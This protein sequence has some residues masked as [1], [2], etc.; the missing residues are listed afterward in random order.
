MSKWF[1]LAAGG[2]TVPTTTLLPAGYGWFATGSST[3]TA[4]SIARR[5]GISLDALKEMNPSLKITS[6]S[7][8]IGGVAVIIAP[9]VDRRPAAP[10]APAGS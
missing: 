2:V 4:D 3:Y 9:T 8:V 7:T 10:A 5:Y 6:A 1:C